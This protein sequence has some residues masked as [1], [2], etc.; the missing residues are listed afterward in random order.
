MFSIVIPYYKK[1]KYIERCL[2]SVLNQ[3]YQDF[4][5]VLVD[6]GSKDDLATILQAKKYHQRINL[7]VQENKGVSIA[8]NV[9]VANANYDYIAFLDADDEWHSQYLEFVNE[10]I[11]N[12]ES[13]K[14]V[15]ARYSSH[16]NLQDRSLQV[17]DYEIVKDYFNRAINNTMFTTSS[18]VVWKGFFQE[19]E[20]F[21]YVLKSGQDVEVWFRIL[22]QYDQLFF[23][24]NIMLFY[25]TEDEN[26]ITKQKNRELIGLQEIF[27]GNIPKLYYPLYDK[28]KN[29]DF[30][31][32]ISKFIYF[33]LYPYYYSEKFHNQAKAILEG[34]KHKYFL[35]ELIY[36]FPRVIGHKLVEKTQFNL[37]LRN[38]MKFVLR[39][40]LS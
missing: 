36:M 7:I 31:R 30:E 3:T 15:G 38:Y 14:I 4:E 21:N 1:I 27:L 8:R 35:L 37:L 16:K 26:Q 19:N 9:G 20:G 10:I 22:L 39:Y 11:V 2:D 23:I 6:D 25:S 33:N 17:L 34:N 32:F 28:A 40:I 29:K 13:V 24:N 12:N 5:I 18:A